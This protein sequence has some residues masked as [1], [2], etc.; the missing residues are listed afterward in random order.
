M[1]KKADLAMRCKMNELMKTQQNSLVLS[2]L[3]NEPAPKL[4]HFRINYWGRIFNTGPNGQI[5]VAGR[6][7]NMARLYDI[8]T[9][10]FRRAFFVEEKQVVNNGVISPD[11]K[12]VVLLSRGMKPN[13]IWRISIFDIASGKLNFQEDVD[14]KYA[15]ES[16]GKWII[17]KD[18]C[19]LISDSMKWKTDSYYVLRINLRTKEYEEIKIS[20]GPKSSFLQNMQHIKDRKKIFYQLN[21]NHFVV[22]NADTL[23]IQFSERICVNEKLILS[24]NVANKRDNILLCSSDGWIYLY[25]LEE[26]E[27]KRFFSSGI[28]KV[29]NIKAWFNQKDQL[30]AAYV[31]SNDE[32]KKTI[33]KI[34]DVESRQIVYRFC[35]HENSTIDNQLRKE[36]RVLCFSEKIIDEIY[37]DMYLCYYR[38]TNDYVKLCKGL[39]YCAETHCIAYSCVDGV[40]ETECLVQV[41][42]LNTL[43]I[44]RFTYHS[45]IDI[46]NIVLKENYIIIYGSKADLLGEE[47]L[48]MDIW[49]LESEEM[50][51]HYT[52]R[53]SYPY[54]LCMRK[55]RMESEYK[56]LAHMPSVSE[57]WKINASQ[58]VAF[59]GE[60]ALTLSVDDKE[61]LIH[62]KNFNIIGRVRGAI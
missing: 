42:D 40:S 43:A 13:S 51:E 16:S 10:Q 4:G 19:L 21:N 26:K 6:D 54:D 60:Y 15:L 5:L 57:A 3:Y 45:Q 53:D 50:I 47:F 28:S 35:W 38:A 32:E 23:E 22:A 7:E 36:M 34:I 25:N 58:I 11:A 44:R 29:I 30:I 41:I 14:S 18:D 1:G 48:I 55:F 31:T 59:S 9:S 52:T 37:T 2:A 12:E 33:V 27:M 46:K 39:S 62:D 17:F 24:F 8:R 49:D 56:L 20:S 61:V